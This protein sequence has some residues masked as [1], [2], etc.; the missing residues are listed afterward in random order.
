MKNYAEILQ[1]IVSFI[2][3]TI[4]E[5]NTKGF[6]YGVSGG[7]D[8]ALICAIASNYFKN[9]SL[10]LRMDIFNSIKDQNDGDLVVD[11]F[12]VNYKKINLEQIFNNLVDIY[13]LNNPN[14]NINLKAR[15]RMNTLYYFAQAN[16]YLV[17]GTSNACELFTGYF[18]K[19]GD[20]GCDF[21]PIANLTKNDVKQLAKLLNVPQNIIDKHPSAGLY[22]NQKDETELKVTYDEIDSYLENKNIDINA[23]NRIEFLHKSSEHKRSF[24]KTIFKLNLI[25][26]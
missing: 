10:A 22:E 18:T 12:K 24:A 2:E 8:S 11:F 6:V 7:I 20:S 23:K 4:K 21:A 3:Q 16:K 19:F 14:S 13:G 5:T 1:K 15:L 9:N 17:C 26:K 25:M